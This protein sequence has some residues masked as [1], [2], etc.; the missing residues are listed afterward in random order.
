MGK[1]NFHAENAI[2]LLNIEEPFLL[3]ALTPPP[4]KAVWSGL[5]KDILLPEGRDKMMPFLF[6]VKKLSV[7]PAKSD[8]STDN[9]T[10]SSNVPE[11][12]NPPWEV[13]S[14]PHGTH[15]PAHQHSPTALHP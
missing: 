9:R 1:G 4:M 2:Q 11:G 8:F 3:P 15:K 7:L 5:A 13:Q 12:S 10:A 6:H 14:R